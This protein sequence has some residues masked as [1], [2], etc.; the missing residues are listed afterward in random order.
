[1]HQICN[2]KQMLQ[3]VHH[4]CFLYNTIAQEP[5]GGGGGGGGG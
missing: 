5:S 4:V 3:F 1:M 2:Q